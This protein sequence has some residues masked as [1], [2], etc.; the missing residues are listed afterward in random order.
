MKHPKHPCPRVCP[1][2]KVGCRTE[3]EAWQKYEKE[4]KEFMTEKKEQYERSNELTQFRADMV[5][6][7]RRERRRRPCR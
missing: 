2:R 3:C 6:K 4:Y 1:K 7:S 5:D